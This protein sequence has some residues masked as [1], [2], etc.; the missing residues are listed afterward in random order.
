MTTK[1]E[2]AHLERT[3]VSPDQTQTTSS[4]DGAAR[5][6]LARYGTQRVAIATTL[7]AWTNISLLL[8]FGWA[9]LV[10]SFDAPA[11]GAELLPVDWF[12]VR[13]AI[14]IIAAGL[15]FQF[16]RSSMVPMTSATITAARNTYRKSMLWT[17]GMLFLTG[18]S[19]ALAILLLMINPGQAGKLLL[20]G[21]LEVFVVQA[22]F[23]GY[24]KTMLEVM[25]DRSRAT[26]IVIGLFAT[27]FGLQSFAIAVTAVN[28]GQNYWLALLAG[29]FLGAMVGIVTTLLR[30][31][32]GSI[33]PGFLVQLLVFSL[34]IPFLE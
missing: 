26:L 2:C 29:A 28:T 22:L 11:V 17:Q 9:A 12:I 21:I 31:R 24:V 5:L 18:I 19:L 25:L 7:F 1:R 3:P 10:V 34:L 23:N 20:F 4:M 33:W 27:F 6:I 14:I 8:A 30:D 13:M 32:S 15:T 16:W